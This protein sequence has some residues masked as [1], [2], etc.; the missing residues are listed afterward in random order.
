MLNERYPRVRAYLGDETETAKIN[1]RLIS[2]IRSVS[3]LAAM[4]PEQSFGVTDHALVKNIKRILSDDGIRI[5]ESGADLGA[6]ANFLL[7]SGHNNEALFKYLNGLGEQGGLKKKVVLLNTCYAEAAPHQL[8]ELIA[9]HGASGVFLHSER[10]RPVAV[11]RVMIELGELLREAGQ[12]GQVIHPADLLKQAAE[13]VLQAPDIT[14]ALRSEIRKFMRG[15]LQISV[16]E[17]VNLLGITK[18][19]ESYG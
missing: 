7:I 16:V 13:R 6:I 3:Y 1:H 11:Q 8:H 2:P 17:P 4:V 15:A 14:D 19:D 5:I 12:R 10:I 18:G 9:K